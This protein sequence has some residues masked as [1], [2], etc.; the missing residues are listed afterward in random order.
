VNPSTATAAA[1]A[2]HPT[3]VNGLGAL[4]LLAAVAA[5]ALAGLVLGLVAGIR[6][7]EQEADLWKDSQAKWRARAVTAENRLAGYG[8]APRPRPAGDDVDDPTPPVRRDGS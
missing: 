6:V 5:G 3:T 4:H 2:G 7:R 1:L 8:L